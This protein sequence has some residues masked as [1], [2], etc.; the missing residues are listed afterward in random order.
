MPLECFVQPV[1]VKTYLKYIKYYKNFDF[2]R[3][4]DLNYDFKEL[5]DIDVP[6]F[7]RWGNVNE[8]I[9]Q[10]ADDLIKMLN[11]KINI[12]DKDIN[13]IDGADHSYSGKEEVLAGEILEFLKDK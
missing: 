5:N 10:R 13:Y 2:A 7:M 3:Y 11:E 1:S 12:K 8:M 9:E 6:L 4:H